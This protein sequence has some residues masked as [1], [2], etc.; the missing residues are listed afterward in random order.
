MTLA[1]VFI[2]TTLHATFQ[3]VLDGGF[4]KAMKDVT[5]WAEKIYAL[6]QVQKYIGIAQM[7]NK[8]M[9]PITI[10]DPKKEEKKKE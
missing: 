6:S 5:A 3:T 4:R 7:C 9:K 10:P 2:A 8:A 1:D